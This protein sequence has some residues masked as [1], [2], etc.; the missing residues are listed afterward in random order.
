MIVTMASF[1]SQNGF[2]HPRNVKNIRNRRSPPIC[3]TPTTGDLAATEP[4]V[5]EE[6]TG[7]NS[8]EM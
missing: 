2:S 6:C 3:Y 8:V 1:F 7:D 4:P 5:P